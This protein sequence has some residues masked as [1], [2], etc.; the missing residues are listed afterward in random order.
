MELEKL[1]NKKQYEACTSNALHLRIIAGAGTGKTRTL[2]YRIFYLLSQGV[3][4]SKILAITFTRKAADEM[5]QRVSDLLTDNGYPSKAPLI[6]NFHGFCY[7]F[8]RRE[9][10]ILNIYTPDFQIADEDD[11]KEILKSIFK[12]MT[13][14][15][16][17]E[18]VKAV[19]SKISSLKNDGILAEDIT[20]SDVSSYD[21]F[22]FEDLNYAYSKYQD[23]LRKSNLLDFDD[24]LLY[25]LLILERYPEVR[26]YYSNRYSHVFVDEFQDTNSVQYRLTKYLV[27]KNTSLTVV[28]DPDQTIYTWRGARNEIIKH[29]LVNDYRDLQTI[30]LDDNYRSTQNI[31][32][33][34]NR[35][36]AHNNDR[37]EKQ[38]HSYL[39]IK[40]DEPECY[41]AD[42]GD[43]EGDYIGSKIK[44]LLTEG[45]SYKDIAVI[46]RMNYVSASIE[47]GLSKRGI[48]YVIYGGIPFFRRAEVKDMLSYLRIFFTHDDIS[49]KRIL[50]FPSKGI[51][52]TSIERIKENLPSTAEEEKNIFSYLRYHSSDIRLTS[53]A[54]SELNKFYSVY[55][56][57][58][59]RIKEEKDKDNLIHLIR[60][61]LDELGFFDAVNRLDREDMLDKKYTDISSSEKI[62][63]VKEVFNSISMYMS[64]ENIDD[65]GN[66]IVPSLYTY[67]SYAMMQ[68]S[69]DE[70]KDDNRVKLMTGHIS[71]GLEFKVVF[72]AGINNGICP[73]SRAT[74]NSDIEEERRL[75]Y[76]AMT[77]AQ[78]KLFLSYRYGH[79]FRTNSYMTPSIFLEDMNLLKV[80]R[81]FEQ[82]SGREDFAF[83][84]KNMLKKEDDRK[85]DYL[86]KDTSDYK[87][88]DKVEHIT[89]GK[90]NV[91]N[92]EDR[93]GRALLSIL[94][95]CVNG[96]KGCVKKIIPNAMSLK[97]L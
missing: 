58:E 36:I 23:Y 72:V 97:K 76:V 54:R 67:L 85:T 79:D 77:R 15:A 73:S 29:S 38:L 1:L 96:E 56:K 43:K 47:K 18:F 14:G 5:K 32:D 68:S 53:K 62:D 87:I 25:T 21:V 89:F 46:Y 37:V 6:N 52:E 55:E 48:P 34:S 11:R 65:Q 70:I 80:K 13:N 64:E 63:N 71:K 7:L 17:K 8:L 69:Q 50:N 60:S 4:A 26:T 88:G 91:I 12:T 90:G 92:I 44:T 3:P 20:S 49:M 66:R 33:L 61:Y 40:G 24:L 95:D 39:N 75:L 16:N 81:T 82:S 41:G 9:I 27:G 51:G 57:Y 84:L 59:N 83:R 94:F 86:K 2:T 22:S 93:N 45:Y 74:S 31:L 10:S 28:G 19:T 78:E 35:L 42:N 30:V